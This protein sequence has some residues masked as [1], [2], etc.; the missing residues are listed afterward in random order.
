MVSA[1]L[2]TTARTWNP[3]QCPLT[4]EQKKKMWHMYAMEYYSAIKKG[5]MV[6]LVAT[7]MDLDTIKLVKEV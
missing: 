1:A 6:P 2:F 7:W 3:P 4:D 5:E